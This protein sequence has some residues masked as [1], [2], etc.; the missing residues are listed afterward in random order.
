MSIPSQS[1]KPAAPVTLDKPVRPKLGLATVIMLAVSRRPVRPMILALIAGGV[2]VALAMSGLFRPADREV[3][4][5]PPGV[6]ALV[7][8]EPVLEADY[9]LELEQKYGITYAEA[10][11]AQR[12]EYL[13]EMIDQELIVQHALALD[14][15][16]QDTNVRTALIDS[17][18]ALTGAQAEGAQPDDD[19]LKAY[20]TAHADRYD[21]G[22]SMTLTDLLIKWGSYEFA[23]QTESQAMADAAQAAYE[24]KSGANRDY[25]KQHYNM[26]DSGRVSGVEPDFA[27]KARLGP[28][29]YAVAQAMNA[30]TVSNP[31]SET[32]GV[33]VLIMDERVMPIFKGFEAVKNS[34]YSDYMAE[35]RAKSKAD[36]VKFLRRGARIILAP[37]LSE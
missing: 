3:T 5:V 25:V 4:S 21:T 34:V 9:R 10:T 7:N 27:A 19:V 1:D 16:E 17:V 26:I 15:P 11:K 14:L 22:G 33:H 13:R 31:V 24:L 30:G 35:Q 28:K 12:A 37:G 2:G 32:D 6:V 8:G 29:L 23:A 18:G 20:F 36:N